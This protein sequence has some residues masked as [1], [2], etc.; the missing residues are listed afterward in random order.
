[1]EAP[2]LLVLL[3][4]LLLVAGSLIALLALIKALSSGGWQGSRRAVGVVLIGPF[5]II[6]GGGSAKLVLAIVLAALAAFLVAVLVF[7]AVGWP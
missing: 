3:G 5:P 2:E 7:W 1:M 4:T 6:V